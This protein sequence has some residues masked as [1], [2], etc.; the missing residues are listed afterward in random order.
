[1]ENGPRIAVLMGGPSDEHDVSLESGSQVLSAL[2][3]ECPLAV[4]IQRDGAWTIDGDLI[5]SAGAALDRL[6][7]DVDVVFIALHGPFGEDGT[8]QG[9]LDAV[10]LPYTG[11][12]LA[13]SSI[14]MDKARAKLVYVARDLPTPAFS[15]VLRGEKPDVASIEAR[16]GFPCVVKPCANGSSFG[17]SFPKDTAELTG[18]IEEHVAAGREV[19]VETRVIGTELTCGVVEIEGAA[20]A[21]PVTEI[22]PNDK[23]DFFDYEAK[24]TPGATDEITPARIPDDLKETVQALALDS[25]RALGCRDFS[26]TDFM[27]DPERGPLI[28]E[29]NT[30][31]GLTQQ[32]L[33]PQ[34]AAAHGISFTELVHI[35]IDNATRRGA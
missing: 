11:S 6:K 32:S 24:Y 17:V 34:A 14:A 25:H 10:Q 9:L 33:L 31:P 21:M 12:G 3:E 28:L 1:M 27:V 23:Y 16:C 30:I 29:T 4:V 35:L 15:L 2:E 26:R 13:G 22:V 20:V 8:V 5:G 18:A 19:V 7:R